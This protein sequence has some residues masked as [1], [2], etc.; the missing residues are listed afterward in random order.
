MDIKSD[1]THI[2]DT[3]NCSGCSLDRPPPLPLRG[4]P[5]PPLSTLLLSKVVALLSPRLRKPQGILDTWWLR[6]W[7]L[8][9]FKASVVCFHQASPCEKSGISSASL[10]EQSVQSFSSLLTGL[11]N[12]FAGRFLMRFGSL[13]KYILP[14]LNAETF[15]IRNLIIGWN[16]N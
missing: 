4:L 1:S 2:I 7:P 8:R 16:R 11:F 3:H 5:S 14:L 13:L 9:D 12:C 6:L 15:F 10:R